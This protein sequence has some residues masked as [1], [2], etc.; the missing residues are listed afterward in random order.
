MLY[1]LKCD[2]IG[3]CGKDY[4]GNL[5]RC[6][7]CGCDAAFSQ[8]AIINPRDYVYD[9]ETY[10]NAFTCTFIHLA[11]DQRWKFEISTRINQVNEFIAFIN[12]LRGCGARGV[13]YNNEAFDYPVIHA[14]YHNP[15]WGVAEIYAHAQAI[16]TA[17]HDQKFDF[18]VWDR[19]RIFEQI[20]LYKIHHFDNKNKRTSLKVLEIAMRLPNVSDLPFPVGTVLTDRQI[21]VLLDYNADDCVATALFYVRTISMIKLRERLTESFGVNF[22]NKNDVKMGEMILVGEMEK[23]GIEC[24]ERVNNRK[25]KKQTHRS[26]IALAD[27]IFPYVQFERPEFQM[28]RDYLSRQV[29]TET[30]GV[31]NEIECTPEMLQYMDPGQIKVYGYKGPIYR[32]VKG[33][34]RVG[35]HKNNRPVKLSNI[36]PGSDVTGVRYESENLHCV[37]DGFRYDFGTGGIHASVSSRVIITDDTMQIVDVDVASFYPNL[38]IKN[39]MFP[40]HLGVE[41]GDAYLGVYHTRKSYDKS[42]PENGAFKLALNGAFGGSNNEHSPFYDPKYTMMITV[43]GQLLLCMLA[44]QML[45][46]PGLTMIQC[47]TDGITYNCPKQYIDHQR[48]VC[49]WWEQL[50]CLEL[51]EALYSRMFIRD[52]NSY[53]AEY[54]SGKLKRIGAYAHVTP[55]Q[56]PATRERVWHKDHSALIVPK[57]AEK[58]LTEGADARTLIEAHRDPFDF[59]IRAKVS[60]SDNLV[61]CYPEYDMETPV[62]GTT[63]Y[64]VSKSGGEITKVSPPSDVAGSWKRAPG[65]K[66]EYYRQVR[67]ELLTNPPVGAELDSEG[68]PYDPRIHTKSK[69]K[70]A[71]RRENMCAGWRVTECADATDFV[72]ADVNVDYYVREV[73]KL[74]NPLLT[75]PSTQV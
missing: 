40:A 3:G 41:F 17:P 12:A 72:L 56:V 39:R 70:H 14:L 32:T 25:V 4:A 75:P 74:V 13:G 30:K 52:V 18:M 26:S 71:T 69:S 23:A 5:N 20:D 65:I 21:D 55:D 60:R 48:A 51:E 50:T 44:E 67:A 1:L 38:G 46:I 27:C 43:N 8:S 63:R 31:F 10:P 61:M 64:Y 15:W 62:Q 54:E 66:D 6:P 37:I 7:H 45:K 19:D 49:K 53:I 73:E 47:N 57:V 42:L 35:E 29:I 22:M 36:P 11:T 28:I 2:P 33:E 34:R 59:M 58:V 16:I 68:F 9:I 24:F